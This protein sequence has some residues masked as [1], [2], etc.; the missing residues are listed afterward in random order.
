MRAAIVGLGWWG[1]VLVEATEAHPGPLRFTH[2]V[3]RNPDRARDYA[4]THALALLPSLAAALDDPNVDVIVLATPHSLHVDQI[5]QCA[6]A[7]KPVFSEKPLALSVTEARRAIEACR[8]AGIVLGLGTDRRML[9]AFQHLATLVLDGTLGTILQLE[10]QYSNDNMS[11]GVSG[12][13]RDDPH[14]APAGG[15]SG[16]GLHALDALISLAGPVAEVSGRLALVSEGTVDAIAMVGR[17]ASGS[18][19]LLGCVR[20]TPNYFRIAVFG[21]LGWAEVRGFGT[22][23]WQLKGEPCREVHYRD[24]LAIAPLLHAFAEAAAGG[25]PFPVTPLSMLQTVA[26]FEASVSAF[27]RPFSCHQVEQ[28]TL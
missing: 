24:Q 8:A 28:V 12:D 6:A 4:S 27:E 9:P 5:R 20:G 18:A 23:T 26:A 15:M 13:W 2:A 14:E 17:F 11:A 1:R 19:M 10:A 21:T 22:C 25:E 16:P 7:G 3:V